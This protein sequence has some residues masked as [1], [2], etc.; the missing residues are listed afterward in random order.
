[1][2][3]IKL[4]TLIALAV[5]LIAC[6][7][8]STS[9]QVI[10][11][12]KKIVQISVEVKESGHEETYSYALEHDE[13][14]RITKAIPENPETY[15]IVSFE[16]GT[17]TFRFKIGKS[18][19][20]TSLLNKDGYIL[21]SEGDIDPFIL[22]EFAIG[23]MVY[24]DKGQLVTIG[25]P[26]YEEKMYFLWK[27]DN[28]VQFGDEEEHVYFTYTQIENKNNFS[29]MLR[30]DEDYRKLVFPFY[31]LIGK[32]TKHLPESMGQGEVKITYQYKTDKDG[33][34]TEIVIIYPDNSKTVYYRFTYE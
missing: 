5:I 10:V 20:L 33:F 9:P 25:H 11:S 12:E 2:K 26:D 24:N 29:F 6:T 31:S 15:S 8:K 13:K 28:M 27:D 30:I 17:N 22:E 16:Y 4:F 18:V 23:H 34:V 7:N 32:P 19:L 14:G 3:P 21:S 1:M